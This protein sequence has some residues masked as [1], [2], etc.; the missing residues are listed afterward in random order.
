MMPFI[1]SPRTM[2]NTA[3]CILSTALWLG[4]AG[5]V[6]AQ[7]PIA[8][9]PTESSTATAPQTVAV[10]LPANVDPFTEIERQ[11]STNK[12]T[13][14]SFVRTPIDTKAEAKAE[15]IQRGQTL[16]V[17]MRAK[18]MPLPAHF[19][20]PRYAV[21]VYIPNYQVKMYIGDLPIIPYTRSKKG[22][23]PRRGDSDTAYRFTSLPPGAVFGGLAV[24]A[25]PI[26]FTPIVNDALRPVLVGLLPKENAEGLIAATTVY[27][28]A[29][30]AKGTEG[31]VPAPK[32]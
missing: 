21:W 2:Y 14:V 29:V 16:L 26:R 1:T 8:A 13:D 7:Q 27:S 5:Q 30:P 9:R 18:D 22:D 10:S 15:V 32:N 3:L 11:R 12:S 28:G 19:E 6:A 20:V 31:N 17:R 25:E 4:V 23:G 24:T